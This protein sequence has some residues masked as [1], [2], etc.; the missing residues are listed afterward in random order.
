MQQMQIFLIPKWL[1]NNEPFF[2]PNYENSFRTEYKVQTVNS[3]LR[4]ERKITR[5]SYRVPDG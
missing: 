5:I 1:K 3:A 2:P 4:Q